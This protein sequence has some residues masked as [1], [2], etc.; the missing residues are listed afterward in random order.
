MWPTLPENTSKESVFYYID[1]ENNNKLEDKNTKCQ[2][3]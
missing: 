3:N 1:D 2:T